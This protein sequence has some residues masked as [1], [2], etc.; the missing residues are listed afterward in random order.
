ME[1]LENQHKKE[2]NEAQMIIDDL[3]HKIE[4]MAV[5]IHCIYT[6][7]ASRDD[8]YFLSI[9][10]E[11]D[12]VVFLVFRSIWLFVVGIYVFSTF[13]HSLLIVKLLIEPT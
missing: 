11:A 2:S 3:N 1:M 9:F 12:K 4:A 5:S 7:V 8:K 13:L 10:P 6:S